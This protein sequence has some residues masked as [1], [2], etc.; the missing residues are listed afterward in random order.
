MSKSKSRILTALERA[1]GFASAQ[2][3]H[4]LM[5]RNGDRIGLTT[6]YRGLNKLLEDK[7]V[8]V[9]RREDGEAVYRL[10]GEAHHHHLVCKKCRKTIEIDGGSV[11]K[12]ASWIA[13]VHGFQD[14]G[15][16][17]EVFGTCPSCFRTE[18]K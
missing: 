2:E 7:I 9:M 16:S 8:D 14:V 12:W 6:T 1:G 17:A 3:V 15:H 5:I 4:G 11:E 10:C 18:L 13:S